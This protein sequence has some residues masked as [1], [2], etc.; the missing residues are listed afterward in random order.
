MLIKQVIHKLDH[1]SGAV[2]I[3]VLFAAIG[4]I[5]VLA[6]SSIAPFRDGLFYS[7]FPK[8]SS[9][10]AVDEWTQDGH[11]AQRSGV[12]SEEPVAPWTY[13]WS[14][15]GSDSNGGTG[16][17]LYDAP[18]EARVV[19]GGAHIYVPAGSRGL[20]ALRKTNGTVTWNITNTS[21][22]ST[23]AYDPTTQ[24]VIAGGADG[25]V[26][27]INAST[28]AIVGT[29]NTGSPINKSI[30]LT[31]GFAYAVSEN[32]NLNKVNI[33]NVSPVWTYIAGSTVATP[34]SYS[35]SRDSIIYATDDLYVHSVNN[36]NGTRKWRV[37][38]T[39]NT[40][41]DPAV[42]VTQTVAGTPVGTQFENGWPVIAEKHGIVFVRLQLP[43]TFM[44]ENGFNLG[45]MPNTNSA[46]R[47]Y[48][49]S[50]PNQK[51]L[52][53][54]NLDDGTE[55]FIPAVAYGSTEDIISTRPEGYGVMGSMPIVKVLPDGTEVAYM[56]FRNGSA[57]PPDGRWDGHMGEMVLDSTTVP[58]LAAGDMRFVK[59]NNYNG[60]GGNSYTHI[61]D[62]QTPISMAGNTLFNAHWGA[63]TGVKILDRSS[64]KG[65]VYTDPITT[66]NLPPV[67]RAQKSCNEFN[68]T[69]HYVNNC[70]LQYV[71]DG[72]RYFGSTGFWGYWNVA[73]PPG[74][75]VGSGNTAGTSYSAGVL[76]RYTYVSDGQMIVEGNGGE[77][78]V[79]K[80]SGVVASAVPSPSVAPS[81]SPSPSAPPSASPAVSP[82]P[83][84]SP[85]PVKP[86]DIDGNNKVDIFD[87]NILLTNFGKTGTGIHGDIDNNGK[88]DIF[89]YNALLTNF[90]K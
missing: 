11:D 23:P 68:L 34:P 40:P 1:Q 17:H 48:L 75:K 19:T 33:S 54:L 65:L 28:G 46:V 38:P 73:D 87:Y 62:E 5:A 77:I 63:S 88:V 2:P 35:P 43:P 69:T 51:N 90:G 3:L 85:S 81:P 20:F 26:Y 24:T 7:L 27:K 29:F 14:F 37:K 86:G 47:T 67:V 66:S 74:W 25:Q 50:K 18:K 41:G 39:P 13:Q 58:G 61:I 60:Y 30:L 79:F 45:I 84:L 6:V 31:G 64:T 78:L 4:V 72:G 89:D 71:S 16:N 12:T 56:H 22:N 52:F 80:H 9:Q 49:Q 76:P 55:K 57:N 82:S 44:F 8:Q 42:T 15:N 83:F 36:N 59:M 10:A 32:G 21:F 70:F 53:A